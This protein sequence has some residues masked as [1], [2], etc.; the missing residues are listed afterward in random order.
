MRYKISFIVPV[1][2]TGTYLCTCV[3]S[4]LNQTYRDFEIILVD[5]GST[6]ES[7]RICDRY[8][9]QDSHVRVIHKK[10]GGLI[11]A[12]T[13]GTKESTGSYIC[14]VDSDDWVDNSM[15]EEMTAHISGHE[16]EIISSDY[17]VERSSGEKQY[18]YQTLPPGEYNRDDIEEKVI[19]NLLGQEH[20]Y[21][22]MSRCMKLISRKLILDNLH[23]CNSVIRMGEDTTIMLPALIDCKRLVVMDHK[24]YYHY[25]YVE[26][27]MIHQYDAKLYDNICQLR[28]II[29]QVLRNK[30][31]NAELDIM[32]Q[33]ADREYLLYL[34][35]IIKNEVRGNSQKCGKNI[36]KIVK[37]QEIRKLVK[38]NPFQFVD[39]SN[40]LLYLVLKYPGFLTITMLKLAMKIFY[41]RKPV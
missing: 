15:L 19:P 17:V 35:L 18:I 4:L 22:C 25:R 41:I 23:F 2:N 27:S 14:Y 34:L 7:A 32:L 31:S 38:K 40:R 13:C 30:L 29:N 36:K 10:N 5:D 33:K 6:D 1:Y 3:D 37:E 21:V 16:Q 20:R 12:W 39:L 28:I 24:T 26:K 9:E 8:Q 11:S